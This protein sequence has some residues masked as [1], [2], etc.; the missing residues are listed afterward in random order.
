[1]TKHSINNYLFAFGNNLKKSTA[2]LITISIL[3][4]VG[5]V[6]G[7]ILL[8][9]EKSYLNLLTTK[10]QTL[11]GYI[12]GST[13]VFKLFFPRLFS[14]LFSAVIIFACCLSVYSS[15][16]GLIYLTYQA[17]ITTIVSGT[18]IAYQ[19]FSGI[20]NT[21]FLIAPSNIILLAILAI[22][23]SIS[24]Q[25]A[26]FANKYK[27]AF[28]SSFSQSEYWSNLIICLILI[29]ILNILFSLILP[30]VIRGIYLIYY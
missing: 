18:L 28:A 14:C 23:Y 15:F 25:R 7:I 24:Y 11:L 5:I 8:Y 30:T 22:I 9:G 2:I 10:N 6:I 19:G 27:L 29:L 3:Y 26:K 1:M 4:V 21:I 12:S 17:T 20:I 13:S 16:I